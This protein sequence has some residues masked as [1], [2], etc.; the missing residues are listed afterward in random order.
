MQTLTHSEMYHPVS[1][2]TIWYYSLVAI[3]AIIHCCALRHMW[4]AERWVQSTNSLAAM[5]SPPYDMLCP[6]SLD[7]FGTLDTQHPDNRWPKLHSLLLMYT[8]IH[9]MLATLQQISAKTGILL[10]S[11]RVWYIAY[12]AISHSA[13]TKTFIIAQTV[14]TT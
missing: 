6:V 3:A 2:H 4:N 10:L 8:R 5:S 7:T 13:F 14:T 9:S 1:V 11:W 12:C